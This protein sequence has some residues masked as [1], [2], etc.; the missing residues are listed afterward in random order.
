MNIIFK[1]F[2]YILHLFFIIVT[3]IG[4]FWKCD[5][6]LI[7]IFTLL[8]WRLNDNKC[9]ITQLEDRLFGETLVDIY[10]KLIGRSSY[11]LNIEYHFIKEHFYI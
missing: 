3:L 8:S 4:P 11:I 2:F 7:Q 10:F 1:F 5:I 6:V 9:I